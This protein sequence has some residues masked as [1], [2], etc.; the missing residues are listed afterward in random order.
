VIKHKVIPGL[1]AFM[2]L[3]MLFGVVY[4]AVTAGGAGSK[5]AYKALGIVILWII[6]G[7]IWVG[8]NPNKGHAKSV[9]GSRDT[10]GSRVDAAPPAP[11]SV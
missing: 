6:I 1:G 2:N 9:T 7:F 11:A 4:L 8:I 10:P 3:A 5:D